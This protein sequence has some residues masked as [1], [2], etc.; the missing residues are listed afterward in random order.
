MTK[1]IPFSRF[2]IIAP[3]IT[4]FLIAVGI[5]VTFFVQ[6]GVNLG[7]DFKAGMNIRAQIAPVAF[8]VSYSGEGAAVLNIRNNILTM[9]ITGTESVDT[10]SYPLADYA[11]LSSL[12][13]EL[14][15]IPDLTV[16]V[17]GDADGPSARLLT[18][19]YPYELGLEYLAINQ[20]LGLEDIPVKIDEVRDSLAE[21]GPMQIQVVGTAQNQ[22]FQIRVEEK[23]GARDFDQEIAAQIQSLLEATFG[24][25]TVLIR[26]IDYVGARFSQNLAQQTIY[27]SVLALALILVYVWFRFRL[28][29]AVSAI[30]PLLHDSLA[31]LAFIGATRMEISTATIAALL[32]IIGYSLNDTI[33]I[34]DRV[35]ENTGIMRSTA[36]REIVDTSISQSLSR[37]LMTSLTTLLAVL[38]IFIFGS[39]SIKDFA[40]AVIFGVIVGTYSSVFVASPILLGWTN[41]SNKRR[42]AKDAGRYGPGKTTSEAHKDSD[43]LVEEKQVAHEPA[44]EK[45]IPLAER[46]LKGKRKK[47]N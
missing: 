4:V 38:A 5:V 9:E 10:F 25:G 40:L 43:T 2:R 18:L 37:T 26:Q 28:A 23:E 11:T 41:L 15:K 33:V 45:D 47:K 3:I 20:G 46:K 42:R 29:Y 12:S 8:Q 19:N 30:V 35:R 34:F 21:Y 39:G 7:I 44:T 22:E 6:G 17:M 27:L 13:A 24:A 16:V 31:M 32:T 1:V 14:V 36:F